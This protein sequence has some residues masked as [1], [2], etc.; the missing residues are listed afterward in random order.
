[1]R[2]FTHQWINIILFHLTCNWNTLSRLK[3]HKHTQSLT[4]SSER[5]LIA[6][7][8]YRH[9]VYKLNITFHYDTQWWKGENRL[10]DESIMWIWQWQYFSALKAIPTL[11][12]YNFSF[13]YFRKFCLWQHYSR[14]TSCFLKFKIVTRSASYQQKE[15]QQRVM[16]IKGVFSTGYGV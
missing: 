12:L 2:T 15:Q 1:M 7:S 16:T 5:I 6:I 4:G 10:A 11:Y 3:T 14:A 13:L 8:I 9:P